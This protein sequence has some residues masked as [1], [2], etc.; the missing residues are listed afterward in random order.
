[1]EKKSRQRKFALVNNCVKWTQ[2][3]L[4]QPL[5]GCYPWKRWGENLDVNKWEF[6]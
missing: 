4:M 3:N 2:I 1:M 5:A 6:K